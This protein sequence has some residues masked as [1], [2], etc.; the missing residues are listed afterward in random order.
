MGGM[1]GVM[2]FDRETMRREGRAARPARPP[3][4]PRSTAN[5]ENGGGPASRALP[6]MLD[7]AA[8]SRTEPRPPGFIV[9]E[10]LPRGYA[11]LFS[12]DGGTGKSALALYLA[13]CVALGRP[14]WGQSSHQAPVMYLSFED[15]D[16][17]C[18]WRLSHICRHLG[19]SIA[20]LHGHLHLLDGVDADATMFTFSGHEGPRITPLHA[21]VQDQIESTRSKLLVVDGVADVNAGGEIDRAAVKQFV[22]SMSRLTGPDG[23]VL[24]IGHVD[25]SA[26]RES[27]T[28]QGYSGSTSWNNSVRARWYLRNA[29][30]P[31]DDGAP[32][33]V[34]GKLVLEIQ[35]SNL[36]PAGKAFQF[37]WADEARMF[38]PV[39]ADQAPVATL[40]AAREGATH[41]WI[42]QACDTAWNDEDPVPA[43]SAGGRPYWKAIQARADCPGELKG[44]AGAQRVKNFVEH[45]RADRRLVVMSVKRRNGKWTDYLASP[46]AA[47]SVE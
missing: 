18:H 29:T 22:R 2:Q 26:A 15:R 10:L 14:V 6:A 43:A 19:V 31:D 16:D 17:V 24:L 38:V 4:Q 41:D 37:Q 13:V 9:D 34:P 44:M 25:K 30:E 28:R 3:W 40:Q 12:G 39:E 46:N 32:V 47:G 7:L 20:D 23:A 36:G 21:W 33:R 42:V 8:L 27:T 1:N 11:T 45:L 35:K 5:A